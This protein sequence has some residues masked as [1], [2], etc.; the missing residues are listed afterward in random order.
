MDELSFAD[1]RQL[2]AAEGWLELGN[3]LEANAEL[4]NITPQLRSH[5][6]VLKLRWQIYAEEKKW[7]ACID[8]AVALTNLDPEDPFGWTYHAYAL[9]ALKRTQEAWDNLLAVVDRFPQDWLMRYN[10]ACYAC[11]MGLHEEA[12]G[13]LERAFL[14]S[15][16]PVKVKL[17][18]LDDPDLQPLWKSGEGDKSRT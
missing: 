8:I 7:E 14:S 5:P 10:L 15:D 9:H 4:E 16:N 3:A 11:Q 6:S 17:M 13:W 12:R 18:A 1:Q 2:T